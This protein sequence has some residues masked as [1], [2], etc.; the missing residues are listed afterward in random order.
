MPENKKVVQELTRDQIRAKMFTSHEFKREEITV[1]GTKIEII[2]PSLGQ[3]LKAQENPDR[4]DAIIDLMIE[5]CYVPGTKEKVFEPADKDG[6]KKFPAGKE[7][8]KISDAIGRMTS[9]DVAD[10]EKN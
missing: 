6:M 5:Y 9:I 10:A 3:I 2:Q 8:V 4:S 1:F 7:I